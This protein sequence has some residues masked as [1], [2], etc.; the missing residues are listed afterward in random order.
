M[1]DI[2]IK[3]FEVLSFIVFVFVLFLSIKV[4]F[5]YERFEAQDNLKEFLNDIEKNLVNI[6]E[7]LE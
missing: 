4:A 5:H 3:I 2:A 6:G 1:V 7:I